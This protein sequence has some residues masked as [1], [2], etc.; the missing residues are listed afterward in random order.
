[1]SSAA[2]SPRG[3]L[4]IGEVL[5]QLKPDFPGITISKIRFL[6]TE[7]LVEPARTPSGYRMF[8]GAD[9]ARLRYVLTQ[10]KEH[11]LPLRVIK[12]QLAALDKGARPAGPGG[13]PRTAHLTLAGLPAAEDFRLAPA[14]LRLSAEDLCH[15]A[16]LR[17]DQ[18]RQLEEFGLI[19]TGR[20]G[21]YD[22]DALAVAK[23]VAELARF[24]LESRHL[25]GFRTAAEREVGLFGQVVGSVAKQRNSDGRARAQ[26]T[27][28]EL[29][30]L[31]VALHAALVRN[32]LRE[33]T[34]P[35]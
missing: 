19:R 13:V 17:D 15:A 4:P 6:E 8:S 22:D 14:Q 34:G 21:R 23:I 25:R 27:V 35:R 3:G 18:L 11:Y 2:S 29:A 33:F 31:S 5:H 10:Q 24:G 32:G 20:G 16:G 30:A 26:D 7:G 28:Q 1:M 9:I 12:E